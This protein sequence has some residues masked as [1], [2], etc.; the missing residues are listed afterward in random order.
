MS[1][2]SI[3]VIRAAYLNR[4]LA[5]LEQCRGNRKVCLQ[6]FNLP[7]GLAGNADA[8]VPL[9]AVAALVRSA[10]YGAD[11]EAFILRV[12]TGL[13][14]ADFGSELR[15]G[16]LRARNLEEALQTLIRLVDREQSNVRYRMRRGGG[17]VR[18]V[19]SCADPSRWRSHFIDEWFRLWPLLAI[20]RHF[21]GKA[22]A[23]TVMVFQS[24]QAPGARM[25]R[26][27]AQTRF[28]I[29]RAETSIAFPAAIL[30]S[31]VISCDA[32]RSAF[33]KSRG[34]RVAAGPATW[35]FATSVRAIVRSYLNDGYPDINQIADTVGYSART[36]QRRLREC[37]TNFTQI[38]QQCRIE[39]A[40][41]LLHDS[42]MR[43][44]DVANAVG[45][46]DPA[47]FSRAFG[48]VVGV[49]PSHYQRRAAA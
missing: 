23:P 6:Q 5:A 35:D 45:Y 47:H 31:N 18:I 17:E 27:F 2:E 24:E 28:Q 41:D 19:A 7:T 1:I 32:G 29:D 48:R 8:Y 26:V 34:R 46:D 43:I 36:L 10:A 11:S 40:R 49:S 44:I 20:F 16:L 38:V 9:K 37:D 39:L 3:P 15:S 13:K 14:L 12:A 33:G 4:C 22:W 21:A 42:D 25:Q 30:E